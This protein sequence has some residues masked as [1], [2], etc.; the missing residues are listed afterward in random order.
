MDRL[1]GS[2][3]VDQTAPTLARVVWW[4]EVSCRAVTSTVNLRTATYIV[5]AGALVGAP[6]PTNQSTQKPTDSTFSAGSLPGSTMTLRPLTATTVPD[7]LPPLLRFI[8]TF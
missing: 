7:K 8:M 6:C 5:D 4:P 1:A 3:K 2:R